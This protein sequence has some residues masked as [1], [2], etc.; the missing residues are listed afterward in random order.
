MGSRSKVTMDE[1]VEWFKDDELFFLIGSGFSAS[2]TENSVGT[3]KQLAD[4]L[5]D[6]VDPELKNYKRE[7]IGNLLDELIS[8]T[9]KDIKKTEIQDYINKLIL[10]ENLN[11]KE[12]CDRIITEKSLRR[13]EDVVANYF[14]SR[15]N[16]VL[17]THKN[18]VSLIEKKEKNKVSPLIVSLNIDELIEKA[19]SLHF[20]GEKRID[21]FI[22]GLSNYKFSRLDDKILW[23]FHGCVSDMKTVV[24]S[25]FSYYKFKETQKEALDNLKR[26]LGRKHCI[27]LGVS[28]QDDH[29][30]DLIFNL[31]EVEDM[32][33]AVIVTPEKYLNEQFLDYMNEYISLA[34]MNSEISDF[35]KT[36]DNLV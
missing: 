32:P 15:D 1:I 26:L 16:L 27:L 22:G 35:L 21:R 19:Y 24:F 5:V 4:Y 28:L 29:I 30:R 11:L 9:D 10:K 25:T 31:H 20:K 3:G 13:Y 23:K 6:V 14:N 7:Q 2:S 33:Q 12:V 34:Y 36:L 8:C 17:D 18:I